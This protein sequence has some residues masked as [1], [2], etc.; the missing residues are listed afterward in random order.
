MSSASSVDNTDVDNEKAADTTNKNDEG[1]P[2]RILSYP[3]PALRAENAEVTEEELESGEISSIV[4]EMFQLMYGT[5]GV[6]LAAPQVGI[7]KRLFVFNPSG[8]RKKWLEEA[9]MINPKIVGFSEGVEC[10]TEGCLSLPAMSGEVQR[11][12]WVKVEA[13]NLKGKKVKKKLKGWEARIFQHELDH[14]NGTLFADRMTDEVRSDVQPR[15]DEL[16][17]EFGEGGVL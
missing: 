12:K 1:G 13:V 5:E 14:L 7:N 6:G 3:H 4:K 9:T 10:G 17:D 11:Y 16:I 2:L 8:D 15:M